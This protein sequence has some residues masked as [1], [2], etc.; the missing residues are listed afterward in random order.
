MTILYFQLTINLEK[1]IG[2]PRRV[3]DGFASGVSAET[4]NPLENEK[5]KKRSATIFFSNVSRLQ[6]AY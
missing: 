3:L 4:T 1:L 2:R 5:L 6:S